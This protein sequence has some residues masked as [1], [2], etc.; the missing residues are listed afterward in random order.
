MRYE[1][2]TTTFSHADFEKY[3]ATY[4]YP[5]AESFSEAVSYFNGEEV[6]T[7]TLNAILKQRCLGTPR[8]KLSKATPVSR[9]AWVQV[10]NDAL[11]NT[12]NYQPEISLGT[13]RKATIELLDS[14]KSQGADAIK[15]MD[16]D[17]LREMLAK[18]TGLTV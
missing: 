2:D 16:A 1:T 18:L 3:E 14:I 10:I 5:Q 17:A 4:E 12:K 7:K 6:V 15:S 9:E 13:S 11:V 8:Q